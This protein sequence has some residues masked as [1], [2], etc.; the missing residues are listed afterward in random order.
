MGG[1]TCGTGGGTGGGT[2]GEVINIPLTNDQYH[3][4]ANIAAPIE[5]PAEL[6]ASA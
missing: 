1:G 5:V 3:C 4:E 6:M 2:A